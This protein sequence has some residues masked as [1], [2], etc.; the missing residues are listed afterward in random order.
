MTNPYGADCPQCGSDNI[1][2][3]RSP[4]GR[5]KCIDCGYSTPH[6][7]WPK[8][9]PS[10]SERIAT[11]IDQFDE[12]CSQSEYTDTGAAWELLND[13]RKWCREEV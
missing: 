11:A 5:T 6:A 4:A 3:Q 2:M 12:V 1:G 8:S 7:M 9:V 13:I 10:L